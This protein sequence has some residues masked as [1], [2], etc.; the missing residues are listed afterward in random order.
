LQYTRELAVPKSI[1]RSFEN[2]ERTDFGLKRML[3]SSAVDAA[4][5]D[6]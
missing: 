3:A 5:G 4:G 6:A 1:A 2:I